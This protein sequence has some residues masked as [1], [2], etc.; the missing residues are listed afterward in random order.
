MCRLGRPRGHGHAK[1]VADTLGQRYGSRGTR[2]KPAEPP[3]GSGPNRRSSEVVRRLQGDTPRSRE[4]CG[5]LDCL[6]RVDACR[7]SSSRSSR[8][9][10]TG[11]GQTCGQQGIVHRDTDGSKTSDRHIEL[12]LGS[13]SSRD[14]TECN[15]HDSGAGG[16]RWP[17]QASITRRSGSR[18]SAPSTRSGC[19]T[20]SARS[21]GS[22]PRRRARP[23][24][25]GPGT[26]HLHQGL[27]R[28][29]R[30]RAD[31]QRARQSARAPRPGRGVGRRE[32]RDRPGDDHDEPSGQA[33]VHGG[34]ARGATAHGGMGR[35]PERLG[36]LR[37]ERST[38]PCATWPRARPRST[39]PTSTSRTSRHTRV[40]RRGWSS[41]P[42][43]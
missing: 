19:R 34:R 1:E 35:P 37:V 43:R 22:P 18:R 13:T 27:P 7:F 17:R 4:I 30:P 11:C 2:V 42:T 36:R 14:S 31:P 5:R 3:R 15:R 9:Q 25:A 28:A 29:A 33:S 26:Q 16:I 41:A 21:S 23:D 38:T 20:R 32:P 8:P 39:A 40:V 24:R 12:P 10:C 6:S